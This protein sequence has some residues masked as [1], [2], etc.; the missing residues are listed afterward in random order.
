MRTDTDSTDRRADTD[1]RGET[2]LAISNAMVKLHKEQF[3]RGP[4]E[5]W[6]HYAGRNM[7][8]CALTNALLP[9]ER[10]LVAMGQQ[11]RVR[12]SR[13]SF[14]AATASEFIDAAQRILGRRV[15]AFASAID[16]D[17][18]VVFENF[19]L[20]AEDVSADGNGRA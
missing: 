17:Q 15:R 4:T 20:E 14:Q 11:G 16:A 1:R 19:L 3:G 5:A 7:V 13:T 12:D 18:D 10:K 6:S 2:L 9:A 8:V